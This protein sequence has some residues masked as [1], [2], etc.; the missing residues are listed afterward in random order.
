[1][2][3]AQHIQKMATHVHAPSRIITVYP[4]VIAVE[5]SRCLRLHRY[6][7]HATFM[8][9]E[10]T[11]ILTEDIIKLILLCPYRFYE[12]EKSFDYTLCLKMTKAR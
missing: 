12:S 8:Y 4:G 7:D 10:A 11:N 6:R 9:P 3:T 5:D 2:Y 1:M